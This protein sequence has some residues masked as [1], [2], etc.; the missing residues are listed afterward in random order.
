ME[1]KALGDGKIGG[2][3]VRYTGPAQK[4]LQGDYFT[5]ET[6]LWID[7]YPVVPVLY[8]HG[9][10]SR[11][12]IR[13]I[14]KAHARADPAGVW[15]E[16]QLNLRDKYEELIYKLV[17]D[18]K[19][20]YSTGALGHLVRRETD[21]KLIS[22]PVAEIT[23]TPNP[24]A[25][26]YLTSVSAAKSYFEMAGLAQEAIV[27]EEVKASFKVEGN[28]DIEPAQEPEEQQAPEQ[29]G[30]MEGKKVDVE[31]IV[32]AKVAEALKPFLAAQPKS[33]Y[34]A[35][36]T[37]PKRDEVKA[38]GMFL[39]S[40]KKALENVTDSEGGYLIPEQFMSELVMGLKDASL[41]RAAGARVMTINT[42]LVKVPY[43]T[44]STAAVLTA[45]EVDYDI[46]DPSFGQISFTPFKYTRKTLVTEELLADSAFDIWG[47]ALAPDYAQAFAAAENAAFTTGTGTGQPEGVVT[48]AGVGKTTAG[49]T[50]ITADE[51][52]DLYHSL[53]Y[54]YRNNAKWMMNDATLAYIRKL[55]DSTGQYLWQPGMAN[56]QPDTILGRPVITNNS[57]AT[58]AATAKT[59][60]FGDFSYYWIAQRAGFSVDR[61]PWL[62][63]STGQVAFFARERI[64]GRVMLAEAFKV[65]QQKA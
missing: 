27:E 61:N 19:L 63:M 37:E 49:A 14:G 55:K 2:Y 26:P 5:P 50:A 47:Q 39:R 57:M 48:G 65:L 4:D 10:D 40:G 56:G 58:I 34:K 43:I 6:N 33:G 54:L 46:A 64:D 24:A 11:M 1:V 3:G 53:G 16:A 36:N 52:I 29:A 13:V 12:D 45:K 30:Q 21:G 17:E 35:V 60:L 20:G 59:V 44:N 62:Y 15:Y 32:E 8:Q 38:F 25:G 42:D 22:W 9:Q 18:G 31:K 51:I 23:L 28:L 41:I 7:H